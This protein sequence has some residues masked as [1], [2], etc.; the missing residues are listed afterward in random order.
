M[1]SALEQI[2]ERLK[3]ALGGHLVSVVLYGSAATGDLQKGYSD[4]NVLCVL[5]EITP[6]DLAGLS[7]VFRWW[8][9]LGN[10]APLLLTR[11]EFET[12]TDCFAIEFRDIRCQHRIL[13]GE[14]V[15]QGLRVE[16]SFYR[17]QV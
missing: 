7:P 3:T 13:F 11:Q 8:R 15:I 14:D 1:E 17:A 16:D 10:P 9:G 4:L 12:S 6:R 2:V 5:S